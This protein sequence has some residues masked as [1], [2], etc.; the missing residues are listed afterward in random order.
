MLKL[1][2]QEALTRICSRHNTAGWRTYLGVAAIALIGI[3]GCADRN[4]DNIPESP[5][6]SG[7]VKK[8]VDNAGKAVE[9]AAE[10]TGNVV[11]K[12]GDVAA[13]AALTGKVKTALMANKMV[14]SSNINVDTK[15]GIIYLKGT[16]ANEAQ[17]KLA[18]AIT[19]KTAAG[20]SI[21]NLLK[22][23]QQN[24]AGAKPVAG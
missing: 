21:N 14:D 16:V 10:K 17:R 20:H 23:A 8:S 22:T 3:A 2:R 9:N 11:S 5:A 24:P 19:Q 4:K 1:K 13:D 15:N 12:A 7:E 6:T 18:V